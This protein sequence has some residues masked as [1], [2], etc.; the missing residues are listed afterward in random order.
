MRRMLPWTLNS[1]VAFVGTS[2][3][4]E[5]ELTARYTNAGA[6]PV[7]RARTSAERIP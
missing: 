6:D 1:V 2:A 3:C 4:T 5:G 7:M